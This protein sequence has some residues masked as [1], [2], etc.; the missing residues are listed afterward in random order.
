[1]L[2]CISIKLL[3][4]FIQI[5]LRHGCSPVTLLHI[6]TSFHKSTYGGLKK[7]SIFPNRKRL[8]TSMIIKPV[9]F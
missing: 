9:E 2:K 6:R 3:Y 1:M 7:V 4:N 8:E 5:A